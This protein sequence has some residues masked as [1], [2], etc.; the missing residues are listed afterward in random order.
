MDVLVRQVRARGRDIRSTGRPG[1]CVRA[2]GEEHKGVCWPNLG[3]LAALHELK[4]GV[5]WR[6]E[7][8]RWCQRRVRGACERR[9]GGAGLLGPGPLCVGVVGPVRQEPLGPGSV[10]WP[11]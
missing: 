7:E 3:G 5:G 8:G 1:G 11:A 9:Q 2:P 4:G 10:C 6:R